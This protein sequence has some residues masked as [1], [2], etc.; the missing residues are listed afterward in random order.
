MPGDH[1]SLELAK[2]IE[3]IALAVTQ[4]VTAAET[5]PPRIVTAL[6][7]LHSRGA[8]TTA[9]LAALANVKH[10]SMSATVLD[11]ELKGLVDRRPHPTDVRKILIDLNEDGREVL[12]A[13]HARRAAWLGEAI[14]EKVQAGERSM[15]EQSV[16]VLG[17]LVA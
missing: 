5:M 16:S 17:K 14:R 15:L 7:Q 10:Q 2:Q 8:L 13:E 1:D 3:H 9:D 6:E 12:E 11:L 4:R